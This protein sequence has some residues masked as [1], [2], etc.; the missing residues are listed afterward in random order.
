MYIIGG[1]L[2][3]QAILWYDPENPENT[4]LDYLKSQKKKKKKA[5]KL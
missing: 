4:R 5:I 2:I 1:V 3:F